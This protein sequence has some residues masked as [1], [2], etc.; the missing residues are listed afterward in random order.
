MR[1]DPKLYVTKNDNIA[2]RIREFARTDRAARD[3]WSPTLGAISVLSMEW[4]SLTHRGHAIARVGVHFGESSGE[5]ARDVAVA[6]GHRLR[7]AADGKFA[8]YVFDPV[9]ALLHEPSIP[10]LIWPSLFSLLL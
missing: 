3:F 8:E 1:Q 7:G 2:K 9:H 6:V 10:E 5:T 4:R